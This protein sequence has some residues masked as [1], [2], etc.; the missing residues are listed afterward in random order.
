M[1]GEIDHI[2]PVLLGC[3]LAPSATPYEDVLEDTGRVALGRLT[4]A[5]L[6]KHSFEHC[7]DATIQN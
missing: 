7:H 2:I 6:C 5:S 1:F 4:V 3:S